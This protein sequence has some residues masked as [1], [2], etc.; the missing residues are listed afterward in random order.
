VRDRFTRSRGGC[1]VA[2]FVSV[3]LLSPAYLLLL[4][5]VYRALYWSA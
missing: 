1:N 4:N 5:A 2:T 3:L